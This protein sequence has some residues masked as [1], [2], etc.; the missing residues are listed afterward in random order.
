MKRALPLI[1][2]AAAFVALAILWISADR[3]APA[4]IYDHYSSANTSGDGLSLAAGYLRK[5]R[6][7]GMLTRP[8]G[9]APIESNAVVFRFTE[10]TP[11]VF[12][13]EDLRKNTFGPPKPRVN[14]LLSDAEETFVRNGGRMI[15][16]SAEVFA[17]TR[18][19]DS[20]V[21]TKVFPIWPPLGD[22]EVCDCATGLV[23]LPPRMHAI[24]ASGPLTVL[25]RQR[26]GNGELFVLSEPA[27][28]ANE[29]LVDTNHLELLTA[30]AGDRRPV[31][32]DEVPHGLMK[33]DGSLALMKEWN[34]GPFLVLLLAVAALVFWRSGRRVGPPEED[35]R[36]TRSDAVDLVRSLGALYD[37][38]TTNAAAIALYHEAL[39][40]TVASQTG[41]RGDAL[42][43]RVDGLT[44][45]FVAPAKYE[46]MPAATFKQ[47]LEILNEAFLG[48][49]TGVRR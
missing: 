19:L 47:Q 6:K 35:Y 28:L 1:L 10:K 18:T 23:D 7:V 9:R 3:R 24:Y 4:R 45:G 49:R 2:A 46:E 34:L 39:T 12:D 36:E 32:F 22:L 20:E 16:G 26:I 41:L 30:L 29:D 27:I 33:N 40:R 11:F 38:V 42:R 14:P 43:K 37:E 31:Y 25:A 48:V 21:A 13:P 44:G 15:V 5:H 17:N 8:L